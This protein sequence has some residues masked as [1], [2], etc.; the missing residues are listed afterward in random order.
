MCQVANPWARR[1]LDVVGGVRWVFEEENTKI[2]DPVHPHIKC[3]SRPPESSL[4]LYPN[5]SMIPARPVLLSG[6]QN[7]SKTIV[8]YSV[9]PSHLLFT[10]DLTPQ[11]EKILKMPESPAHSKIF[12][13]SPNGQKRAALGS[14]DP[15][16]PG[17][18]E[19]YVFIVFPRSLS[20]S[21]YM[22]TGI[23]WP[24]FTFPVL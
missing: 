15:N 11:C 4:A 13:A 7:P 9:F 2:H 19:R 21:Q 3:Y 22:F 23:C 20:L 24:T 10:I 5:P 17:A 18:R 12:G 14:V 8:S 16:T 1:R 6:K